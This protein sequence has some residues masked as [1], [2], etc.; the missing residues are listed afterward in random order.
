M[1]DTDSFIVSTLVRQQSSNQELG[2]TN[3]IYSFL[4]N[5]LNRVNNYVFDMSGNMGIDGDIRINNGTIMVKDTRQSTS[6]ATGGKQ[7]L[8]STRV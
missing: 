3:I 4:P 8:V 2:K 6:I 7:L 5:L 1:Q